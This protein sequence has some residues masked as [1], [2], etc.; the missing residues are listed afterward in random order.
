M[1]AERGRGIN[2][3]RASRVAT[4]AA[5]ASFAALRFVLTS[6]WPVIALGSGLAAGIGFG[7]TMLAKRG[8][9]VVAAAGNDPPRT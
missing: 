1:F 2:G 6:S 7:A 9:D 4:W 3:L 8:R 5:V